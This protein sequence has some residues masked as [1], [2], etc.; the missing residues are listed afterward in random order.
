MNSGRRPAGSGGVR[1]SS[2]RSCGMRRAASGSSARNSSRHGPAGTRRHD[3]DV[4]L[5]RQ[6]PGDLPD[7]DGVAAPSARPVRGVPAGLLA[8][9]VERV[10]EDGEHHPGAAGRPAGDRQ[11]LP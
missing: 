5:L 10:V 2:H 6:P 11:A 1:L 4:E 7:D 9:V 8:R 3:G